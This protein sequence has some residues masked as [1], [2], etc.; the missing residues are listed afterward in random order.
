MA[1]PYDQLKTDAVAPTPVAKKRSEDTALGA[2]IA[3]DPTEALTTHNPYDKIGGWKPLNIDG[4]PNPAEYQI[5]PAKGD[6]ACTV[7]TVREQG[8]PRKIITAQMTCG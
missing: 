1:G 6:A 3:A 5:R 4:N 8:N 2:L 7:K